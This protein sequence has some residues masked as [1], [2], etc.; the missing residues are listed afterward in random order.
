MLQMEGRD[1][2]LSKTRM[3]EYTHASHALCFVNFS[4]TITDSYGKIM[5][6]LQSNKTFGLFKTYLFWFNPFL[7]EGSDGR[8][9]KKDCFNIH[10]LFKEAQLFPGHCI[11]SMDIVHKRW[12]E[13]SPI[14]INRSHPGT[15]FS[16]EILHKKV[17]FFTYLTY[18]NIFLS[19]SQLRKYCSRK[20]H[21]RKYFSVQI[22]PV[23]K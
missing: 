16:I 20:S 17:F 15:Y 23:R 4:G 11:I 12:E 18:E 3:N 14:P 2:T 22:L 21:P 19:K 13:A 7:M 8:N 10:Q 9:S 5:S 1:V 6:S